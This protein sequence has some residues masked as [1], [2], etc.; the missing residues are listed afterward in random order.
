MEIGDREQMPLTVAAQ[1]VQA[2]AFPDANAK[3]EP[4]ATTLQQAITPTLG[5]APAGT[6]PQP[7]LGGGLGLAGCAGQGDGTVDFGEIPPGSLPE[8]YQI[9]ATAPMKVKTAIRWALGRLGTMYQWGG[10]CTDPHGSY[11]SEQCDRSSLT[12]RSYGVAG[13]GITRTTCT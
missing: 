11:P 3:H 4:L 13:K 9:P 10:N 7:G 5:A 12:Q 6:M 8:G 1:K 2:D